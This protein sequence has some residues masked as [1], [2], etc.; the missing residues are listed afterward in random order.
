MKKE[1]YYFAKKLFLLNKRLNCNLLELKL[2][3]KPVCLITESQYLD[4]HN[5]LVK[6]M[7]R[8]SFSFPIRTAC[9]AV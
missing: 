7:F 2:I 8:Q 6:I 4:N 3:N 5:N 1:C 9:T